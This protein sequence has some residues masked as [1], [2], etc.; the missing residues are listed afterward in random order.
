[1]SEFLAWSE[2]ISPVQYIKGI[3]PARAKIL[4]K[5]GVKSLLDLL[6]YFPRTYQDR[7]HFRPFSTL[8]EGEWATIKGVVVSTREQIP[9]KGIRLLKVTVS[10]GGGRMEAVWFNQPYLKK[11][12]PPGAEVILSGRV[13][14]RFG[15]LQISSPDWEIL[16]EDKD[17]IH[18]GRIVPIYSLTAGMKQRALRRK[19]KD[20]IDRYSP[21][22]PDFLPPT[23]LARE[24]LMPLRTSL[25]KIHFPEDFSSLEE[26]RRR[27][28][29]EELFLLQLSFALRWSERK[30]KRGIP[31]KVRGPLTKMFLEHLPFQLTEGQK[32]A[33]EEIEKDMQSSKPMNRLLQGEVGSGK[34]VLAAYAMLAAVQSGHQAALMA[35]TEILAEQHFLVLRE[36]LKDLPVKIGLLTS[37]T[38]SATRSRLL[39]EL[40]GGSLNLL[41]GTH[42][43]LEERVC[44]RKLGLVV[45]DEQHRFGVLQRKI[46]MEKGQSP[47]VLVLTATPIPRS[48]ALTFY[49]D[50]DLSLVKGLPPGRQSIITYLVHSGREEA[51]F[52]F[53]RREVEK[54]R[55]AYIVCPLIDEKEE[56]SAIQAAKAL[57]ERLEKDIFPDM[58][59]GL[60]HG[61][62][63]ANE[64]DQVMASFRKGEIQILVS[65]TV[66]EV[67]IDVANA[68][69]MVIWDADR[70][71]LAQLHQ[72][73]GRIGRGPYKSYCILMANPQR[74]EALRRLD[75][76]V[77]TNDGFVIS[78]EDL[79]IRGPGE[80]FG[81][82]QHGAPELKLAD[83]FRPVDQEILDRCREVAFELIHYQGK[84]LFKDFPLLQ[85]MLSR[86]FPFQS[87]FIEVG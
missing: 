72:L 49:G 30:G 63:N 12:F 51:V 7:T 13:S 80:F 14:R 75:V 42:A 15:P 81:T 22:V 32:Q 4:E 84:K 6:Y 19:M 58:R 54:G 26:A 85:E 3:G 87:E 53:L 31:M 55:Q 44:F 45:I 69:V 61:R 24:N 76:M 82:V 47:D 38:R 9:R 29:F 78:A 39:E 50:Y 56:A 46:L 74:A 77:R 28:I 2:L 73:R 21:H 48:L 35:P 79:R 40:E 25:S 59:L 71:G 27:L 70:F 41:I 10:D 83:L 23:I 33:L 68:S 1:M 20:V 8:K 57:K 17:P 65:T 62:L 11:E 60:L 16:E 67:G 5:V 66:I 34:T 18:S 64:K 36:M 52:N 86:R 43:L 37:G